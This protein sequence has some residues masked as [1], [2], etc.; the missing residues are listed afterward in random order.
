MVANLELT[1]TATASL[2]SKHSEKSS[3]CPSEGEDTA[4]WLLVSTISDSD[5]QHNCMS[6]DCQKNPVKF[7]RL[8]LLVKNMVI[9]GSPLDPRAAA[10][11]ASSGL[12]IV[13][14]KDGLVYAWELSSGN[15]LGTLHD[16]KGGTV[17]CI[18]TDNSGSHA[19]AVAGDGPDG[20]Q[21]LVYLHARENVV[22]Q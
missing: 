22:N 8:A 4:I 6:S 5:A 21:L 12:G 9:L 10:I 18:A 7:W 3:F 1:N 14:T 13:G 15:K 17:S 2:F 11:G 16:F 20:S 19:L